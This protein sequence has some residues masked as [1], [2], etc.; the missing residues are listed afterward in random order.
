M[1]ISVALML[2]AAALMA[3]VAARRRDEARPATAGAPA[4]DG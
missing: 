3:I 4:T 2:V 1:V